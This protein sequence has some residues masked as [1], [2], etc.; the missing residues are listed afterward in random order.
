[1]RPNDNAIYD[2]YTALRKSGI[3]G[4]ERVGRITGK[5]RKGREDEEKRKFI[6]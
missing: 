6:K 1:M 3:A 5:G 2:V 4:M